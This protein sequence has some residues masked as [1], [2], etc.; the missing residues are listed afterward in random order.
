MKTCRILLFGLIAVSLMLPMTAT[1]DSITPESY[2]TTLAVGESTTI[3]KTVTI[4]A[5]TPTTA[6]LDVLFMVDTTGSMSRLI[7][8]AKVAASDILTE[9][10]GFGDVAFAVAAYDDFPISPYGDAS[11]GDLEYYELQDMTSNITAVQN[12]INSLTTHFGGDT[13]ESQLYALNEASAEINWRDASTRVTVWFGDQPGHDAD[14]EPAYAAATGSSVGINDAIDSLVAEGIIVH[15]IDLNNLDET[16][17]A[18]E[19]TTATGGTY[20]FGYD[21]GLTKT[22]VDAVEATFAT[23]DSVELSVIGDHAGVDVEIIPE[24]YIGSYDRSVER[25][26]GFDVTFTGTAPGTYDFE[27]VAT[28]DGN[29]FV[30]SESD[31]I[32]VTGPTSV[33]EPATFFMLGSGLIGLVCGRRKKLLK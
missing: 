6:T 24:S 1:A 28:T 9:L 32:T 27:I 21:D 8:D 31:S 16:G 25:T 4:D 33:P 18:T 20:S 23:Y 13:P 2:S 30:A 7:A 11:S 22:I 29:V 26:F 5:G 14:L 15:A 10:S 3:N 12:A 17:Q 19:I